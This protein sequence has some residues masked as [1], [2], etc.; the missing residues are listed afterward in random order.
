MGYDNEFFRSLREKVRVKLGHLRSG[1]HHSSSMEKCRD[2][3]K[4]EAMLLPLI[5]GEI[6]EFPNKLS[7]II[8]PPSNDFLSLFARR[9]EGISHDP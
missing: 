9:I 8:D 4:I 2:I 6:T 7:N 1:K 5:N 3:E